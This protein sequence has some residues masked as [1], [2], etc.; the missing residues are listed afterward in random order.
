MAQDSSIIAKQEAAEDKQSEIRRQEKLKER[1]V[2]TK[3]D[4]DPDHL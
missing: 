2:E 4:D 3:Y 1:H